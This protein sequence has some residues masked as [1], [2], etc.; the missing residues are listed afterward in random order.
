MMAVGRI[1]PKYYGY[2]AILIEGVYTIL[3]YMDKAQKL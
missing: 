3:Y 1:A 2:Y